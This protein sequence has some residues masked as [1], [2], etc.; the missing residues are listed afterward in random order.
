VRRARAS[1][2]AVAAGFA[3]LFAVV[4]AAEYA[5]FVRALGAL[6]ELGVAGG[7]L[8]YYL[9]ESLMVI[10]FMIALISFV[11]SGLTLYYRARDTRLLLA[12]PLPVAGL[13]AV[14]TVETFVL[15]SWALVVVGLPALVALGTS[16][17][18]GAG[19]YVQGVAVLAA[20]AALVGAAGAL[21]TTAAAAAF[22]RA[23]SRV[24]AGAVIALLLAAFMGVIGRNVVPSTA[25]FY[26]L[27]EPGMLNGKPASIKFIEARFAAWP[28]HPYAAALYTLTTG[29]RA[30]SRAT[31]LALWLA[32]LAALAGAATLGRALYVRT[33]PAIAESFVVGGGGRRARTPARAFPRWLGGPVGALIERD[34][35]TIGRSP[36]ELSR[37]VLIA[38]LLLLY[39]SFIVVAPLREVADR[40]DAVARL[41]LF[42]VV[43]S[44]YFVT[45]FALRFVFPSMS[46]E[47][48][49][50]WLFFSSPVPRLRLLL[51]KAALYVT[52]LSVAVVPIAMIGT[53]RLVRDPALVA[54]TAAL[55]LIVAATATTVLLAFGAAWPDFRQPNPE[56]LTATGGGLAGTVLC[57]VYVAAAGWTVR[58]M[59]L[60]SAA[61]AGVLGW[62][63]MAGVVSTVIAAGALA[64][65]RRRS[66]RLEAP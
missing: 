23:P 45:A 44:G 65:A 17:G 8:T 53:V 25:D 50:A 34:L 61:G 21:L 35:R 5:F 33:L 58:R 63:A 13:Y 7:A 24:V 51:G 64:L 15:T 20:F 55:L 36:H 38:F 60:A 37:A 30:G 54:A 2:R 27:F 11:A 39:T 3:A 10:I 16:Y 49:V 26:V 62:L 6:R 43:A 19:F 22:R 28:S 4:M 48:R 40:P 12:A 57:L 46:L 31:G 32:P 29:G 47:G 59:A 9:L 42:T 1:Q 66:P 14:R 56:A 18:R 41:L 52:L